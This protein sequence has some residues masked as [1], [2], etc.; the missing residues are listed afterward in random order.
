MLQEITGRARRAIDDYKMIDEGDKIA[1]GLS[2]GKDSIS[3]LYALHTLQRYYPKKF[4]LMAITIDPG[5]ETFKT[6]KLK[7]MC[8]DLGIEYVVYES[9][10]AE[11]VFDNIDPQEK[12]RRCYSVL[13]DI[14]QM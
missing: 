3:L 11:I 4:E 8:K 14:S 13:Y 7:K 10:L 12:D 1:V 5:S 2:G 6:D 9:H